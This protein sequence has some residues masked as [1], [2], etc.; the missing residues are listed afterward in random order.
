MLPSI[1]FS[2]EI[3]I[4]FLKK[5]KKK[6]PFFSEQPKNFKIISW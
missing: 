5:K 2:S 1:Y 6:L 4:L 3:A